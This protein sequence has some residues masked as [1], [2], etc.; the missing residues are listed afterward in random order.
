MRATKGK[1]TKGQ[2]KKIYNFS[3]QIGERALKGI[4]KDHAARTQR[5]F[6]PYNFDA[7]HGP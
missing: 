3:G 6:H 2:N 1:T 5:R 7:S 4:V